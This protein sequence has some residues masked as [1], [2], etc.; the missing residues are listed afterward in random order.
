MMDDKPS[1]TL[2]EPAVVGLAVGVGVGAIA[3][4]SLRLMPS[5][6]KPPTKGAHVAEE[7][8][9][10]TL[11]EVNAA[12]IASGILYCIIEPFT[13]PCQCCFQE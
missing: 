10:L 12:R 9:D 11:D 13:Y 6:K 1:P 2:P 4:G 8:N 5:G 3:V 7:F